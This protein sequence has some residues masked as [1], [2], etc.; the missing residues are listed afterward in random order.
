MCDAVKRKTSKRITYKIKK[1]EERKVK[2]F[3]L[4]FSLLLQKGGEEIAP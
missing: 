4:M 3:A 1:S 2:S